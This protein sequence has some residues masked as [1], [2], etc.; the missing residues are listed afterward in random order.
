MTNVVSF[1]DFRDRHFSHGG[2][3]PAHVQSKFTEQEAKELDELVEWMRSHG[4]K[5]TRSS[6]VRALTVDG[7]IAFREVRDA[8]SE[9]SH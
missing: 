9:T 8:E 7:L 4:T 2:T 1:S 6:L 3:R 5:A